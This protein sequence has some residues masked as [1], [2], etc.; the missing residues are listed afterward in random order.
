MAKIKGKTKVMPN[1]DLDFSEEELDQD[2]DLGAFSA[3]S[4]DFNFSFD[5]LEPTR[6]LTPPK[7]KAVPRQ[8]VSYKYAKD[9]AK[10]IKLG[11][12]MEAHMIVPGTFIFG[13]FLEAMFEVHEIQASKMYISTL[14]YSSENVDS[15]RN[16]LDSGDCDELNLIVSAYFYSHYRNS[17]I[18]YTYDQLDT[19]SN[20]FQLAVTGSH[21]KVCLIQTYCGKKLVLHGSPNLRSSACAEQVCIQECPELFDF[22][23]SFADGILKEY[24]TINKAVRYKALEKILGI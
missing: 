6:V 4:Q 7:P 2:W 17:A 8:F 23:K 16:I 1:I 21:C 22:H 10:K 5:E 12:G 11:F 14:S 9:A 15:L 18:Q 13:D 19:S 20:K 3:G 24:G